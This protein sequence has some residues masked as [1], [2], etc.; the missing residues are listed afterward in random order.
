MLKEGVPEVIIRYRV[1]IMRKDTLWWKQGYWTNFTSQTDAAAYV[2]DFLPG[3]IDK[4]RIVKIT[5]IE[6]WVD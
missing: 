4:W 1:D 6:E 2:Y 3:G 5:T